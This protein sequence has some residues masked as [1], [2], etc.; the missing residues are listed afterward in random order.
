MGEKRWVNA[1]LAGLLGITAATLIAAP[2]AHGY[3]GDPPGANCET[4][5]LGAL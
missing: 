5:A 2:T 1:F 3:P 4:N